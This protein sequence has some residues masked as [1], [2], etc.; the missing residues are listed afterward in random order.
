MELVGGAGDDEW[1]RWLR[2]R[3]AG[4]GVGVERFLLDSSGGTAR[5]YVAV[6]REGEP[7]YSFEGGARRAAAHAGSDAESVLAGRPGVLVLGSDTLLGEE[8]RAVTMRMAEVAGA[9]GWTVLS[10]PNLRPGRWEGEAEMLEVARALVAAS[11]VVKCNAGEAAL[12]TADRDLDAAGAALLS[13]GPRVAAVTR[14]SQ[15]AVVF[16]ERGS[17]AVPAGGAPEV[18]D[19]TGAGDCVTG[20][21]AAALAAGLDVAKLDRAMGVAMSAASR[22]LTARGAGAGLPPSHEARAALEATL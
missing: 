9:R 13:L 7:V 8:E 17:V 5:A 18:V 1:G 4:L 21:L 2:D 10:D 16:A 11:E 19:A 14:G 6:S 20:V 12:L 22:V 3:V 15:G